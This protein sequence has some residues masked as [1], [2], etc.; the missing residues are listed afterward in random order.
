MAETPLEPWTQGALFCCAH[1]SEAKALP[2][3][4]PCLVTGVG[5]VPSAVSL[6]RYLGSRGS[7]SF[8]R[9]FIFGVAGAYPD[10]TG[11][12]SSRLDVGQPLWVTQ[13]TLADEGV[14]VPNGFL[15]LDEL[16]LRGKAPVRYT[17]DPAWMEELR[18]LRG[19][20]EVRGATVSSC[21]GTDALSEQRVRRHGAHVETMEGAAF[22]HCCVEHELA[23]VQLRVVSNR[24]G[25]RA[26]AKWDLPLSLSVLAACL[27]KLTRKTPSTRN[28]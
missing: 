12:F 23:W 16:D 15:G 22:A 3:G 20:P 18:G 17:A 11:A 6:A 4:L 8:L 9:V 26:K 2:A 5:K 27:E 13:D 19:W 25:D 24:C 1:P 7:G 21:S 10:T 28:P 14:E